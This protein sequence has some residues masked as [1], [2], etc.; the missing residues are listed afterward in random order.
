M[1]AHKPLGA[2]VWR[3]GIMGAMPP[4][5]APAEGGPGIIRPG[6]GW[7]GPIGPAEEEGERK[8]IR[9]VEI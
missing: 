6:I 1:N 4:D 7:F 9:H 8:L 3:G 5:G 2:P